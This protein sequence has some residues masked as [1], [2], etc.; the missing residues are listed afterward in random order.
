[1][2]DS[3]GSRRGG[4]VRFGVNQVAELLIGAFALAIW[5]YL[6]L[7][8]GGFWRIRP[9][10]P[11]P[12]SVSPRAVV[13]V[14]PARDEA[15][16]IGAAVASLL[17][18]DLAGPF[19]VVVVDDH[20][21]D[22]TAAVARAAAAAASAADRLTIVAAPPMPAGW[23][24]KLWAVRQ[25]IAIAAAMQPE[26]LLLTDADIVHAPDNLRQLVAR[27]ESAA[28]DLV[29]LMVRLH[30]RGVWERLLV[31][32]FVFF[33]FKLYPP[34]WVA[35]PRRRIAAAAGG[36]MLLRARKLDEIGGIDSIRHE[37]IDDCALARRVSTV[38]RVWLGLADQ[39]RSMRPY[40][41]WRPIWDM[42]ARCAFAQLGFSRVL[43]LGMALGM[44]LTYLAP[45]LLLLSHNPAAMALG[46]AAWLGM[47]AAFMPILRVYRC[48]LPVALLLP[49]IALFYMS[50]TIGSAVQYWGGRGGAWKGR[51]Q[52]AA[53]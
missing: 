16:V 1:M 12:A 31:P 51:Y 7:F 47:A 39:T 53:G 4:S 33:F 30:C 50:A 26:Y 2:G 46:L 10:G 44:A 45:P 27:A 32:A 38:G 5:V 52:A 23:T 49:L 40:G 8:R 42:I 34:R 17:A 18:Q 43:L 20:S 29:S 35:D 28:F 25:G 15:D 11:A 36:C 6:L 21:S 19:H 41:S 24:G 48:P 9:E 3:S 22:G 13:A 14:I 37:I